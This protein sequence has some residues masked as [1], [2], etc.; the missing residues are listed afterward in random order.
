[1]HVS[2][3]KQGKVL[4]KFAR[5]GEVCPNLDNCHFHHDRRSFRYEKEDGRWIFMP[6]ERRE[7]GD[8]WYCWGREDEA[9]RRALPFYMMRRQNREGPISKVLFRHDV[10]RKREDRTLLIRDETDAERRICKVMDVSLTLVLREPEPLHG[11]EADKD[12]RRRKYTWR[13]GILHPKQTDYTIGPERGERSQIPSWEVS[14]PE[15][16]LL[17]WGDEVQEERVRWGAIPEGLGD[18]D[19]RDM[20]E[21]L[22]RAPVSYTHLTLPTILLV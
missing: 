4:C 21:Q 12:R 6:Y 10:I 22:R 19:V 15:P 13:R 7:L 18:Q 8:H 11:G 20:W 3:R 1:M 5:L 2:Q 17:R 16:R 9:K 14:P